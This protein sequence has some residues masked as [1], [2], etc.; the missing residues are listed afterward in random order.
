MTAA[1][2]TS[3]LI[4]AAKEVRR[5]PW[6]YVAEGCGVL[7]LGYVGARAAAFSGVILASL[8]LTTLLSGAFGIAWA[9]RTLG[10]DSARRLFK[11]AVPALLLLGIGG[12]LAF[13]LVR[14]LEP[15]PPFAR[16]V[17]SVLVAAALGAAGLLGLGCTAEQRRHWAARLGFTR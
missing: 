1:R 7:G 15:L 16:L 3:W 12:P 10:L 5:L 2:L 13:G 17:A 4:Q 14:V 11:A 9:R 8:A 6:I